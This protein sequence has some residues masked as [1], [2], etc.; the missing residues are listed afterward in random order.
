MF[1]KLPPF[2]AKMYDHFLSI[3]PIEVQHKQIAQDLI[4]R[5]Q[6]GRFLD[7]GTGPGRLLIEIRR[8]NQEIEL[9]GMDI[10]HT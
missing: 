4:S 5:V 10:A 6:H 3:K 7:I 2:G 8:L 1:F 9:F